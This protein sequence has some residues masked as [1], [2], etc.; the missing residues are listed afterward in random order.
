MTRYNRTHLAFWTNIYSFSR[1]ILRWQVRVDQVINDTLAL[2][3]NKHFIYPHDRNYISNT[4]YLWS[5]FYQNR[6]KH[7]LNLT[8][9]FTPRKFGKT[10]IRTKQEFQSQSICTVLRLRVPKDL[11]RWK[12]LCHHFSN[13]NGEINL[14]FY[15]IYLRQVLQQRHDMKLIQGSTC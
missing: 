12:S 5:S 6:V 9:H 13:F 2:K 4:Y 8:V 3:Q 1:D 15:S 11:K 7:F 14:I 10:F